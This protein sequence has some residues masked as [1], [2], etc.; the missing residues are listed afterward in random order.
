MSES[1]RRKISEIPLLETQVCY[2]PSVVQVHVKV[3]QVYEGNVYLIGDE[4]C[5]YRLK[6]PSTF[7]GFILFYFDCIYLI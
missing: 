7:T 6:V 2:P 5:A 4:S 3:L 1:K